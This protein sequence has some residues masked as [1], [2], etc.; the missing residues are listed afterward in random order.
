M[1]I[2]IPY[3]SIVGCCS[4]SGTALDYFNFPIGEGLPP[5]DGVY[6]YT[7]PEITI[8]GITFTTS[9]CYTITQIGSVFAT[10]PVAPSINDFQFTSSCEDLK[11]ECEK[12]K[13]CY[14][15][16]PCDTS[17]PPI[18][19]QNINIAPYVGEF[20]SLYRYPGCWYVTLNE[21]GVCENPIDVEVDGDTPCTCIPN[22]YVI[23]GNPD[24]ITYINTD[25]DFVTVSG[26]SKICSLSYPIVTG[27]SSLGYIY[28]TGVCTN[29]E[30]DDLCFT[31]TDCNDDT[32]VLESNT[33]SLLEF[34]DS[35][36]VIKIIGFDECWKVDLKTTCDCL[37]V[38]FATEGVDSDYITLNVIATFDGR[39]VYSDVDGKI[40]L[41]WDADSNEWV[42][43]SEGYGPDANEVLDVSINLDVD[44]PESIA[45]Q[46]DNVSGK[47]AVLSIEPCLAPCECPIPVTVIQ[48]H[49]TCS[50]CLPITAYKFISC[51]NPS[52]VKY[53]IEDFSTYVGKVV[54]LDCGDCWIVEE[55]DY[56]PPSTQDIV[57]LLTFDTCLSC[58]RKHYKLTDCQDNTNV[59]ISYS[60]LTQ[61]I[62]KVIKI[63]NCT[64]C[65]IVTET[66]E[67]LN[68]SQV[69]VTSSHPECIDCLIPT[70]CECTKLTNLNTTKKTYGYYDCNNTF[71]EVTLQPGES[72]EKVCS[73]FW[74][75]EPAYCECIQFKLEKKSYY[76]FIIPDEFINGK[77]VYSLCDSYDSNDCGTVYWDGTTWVIADPDGTVRWILL[78]STSDD[79][80]YGEWIRAIIPPKPGV[81]EA[82]APDPV[83][84]TSQPCDIEVCPCIQVTIGNAAPIYFH[85]VYIDINGYPVYVDENGN[86]I[87]YEEKPDCW[88]A[89]IDILGF[90]YSICGSQLG[91]P[92]GTWTT[93][94]PSSQTVISELCPPPSKEFTVYDHFETFGECQNGVCPPPVFK[95]NRT[96][97]PGY[98]TPNC[99]PDEY[100]KITCKFGDVMYKVVLEKRYGITN[101]CPDEDEKWLLKKELIDLQ[102]IRDPNYKCEACG[103]PCKSG[104]SYSSCN[105]GN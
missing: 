59:I 90:A 62:D 81:V 92:V 23:T 28:N 24:S 82:K 8:N 18:N 54:K 96:V 105:C 43:T 20:V 95:N 31:L 12:V 74:L 52:V 42:I 49:I 79:C 100:D 104:K 29:N 57:I 60:N 76:A 94:N 69:V 25:L 86:V 21:S 91:C 73:I 71:H 40:F 75:L 77:P 10:F 51:L 2:G 38:N 34:I 32:N 26:D 11:C 89:K 78:S 33:Q 97:R 53:S 99:N 36:S 93:E 41:W 44:C 68:A 3:Y 9:S 58:S 4:S 61:Y 101:C 5:E 37:I 30:C 27:E 70:T 47:I 50:D 84:L 39:N 14:T 48:S 35:E 6:R 83:I 7:G 22:C 1:A 88:Y 56:N 46:W 80:P 103:C 13:T 102:A 65:W 16:Y 98:N 45:S 63:E 17:V 67:Y 55:I 19:T 64:E 72:T 85:P 15:L 87:Y 66:T